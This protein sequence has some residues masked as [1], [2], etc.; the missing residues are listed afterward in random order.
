MPDTYIIY[1]FFFE[2]LEKKSHP[3]SMKRWV[4]AMNS[5]SIQE[6]DTLLSIIHDK[7]FTQTNKSEDYG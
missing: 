1:R 4:D 6:R 7:N 2:W 3:L 5:L